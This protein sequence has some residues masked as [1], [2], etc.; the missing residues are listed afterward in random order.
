MEECNVDADWPLFSPSEVPGMLASSVG[1][2]ASS[3][4]VSLPSSV[5]LHTGH[6]PC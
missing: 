5:F 2:V 6:V 3:V 1:A 4:L